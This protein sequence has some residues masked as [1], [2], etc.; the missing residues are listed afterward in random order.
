MS[1]T[2]ILTA[3][4]DRTAS[5][6]MQVICRRAREQAHYHAIL[7]PGRA[8]MTNL[9]L[10]E[11]V[12]QTGN[13]LRALG[14][15]RHEVVALCLPSGP[16][17]T[18]AFMG[19][20]S[21]AVCAPLSPASTES[22]LKYYLAGLKAK[23][24]IVPSGPSPAREVAQRLGIRIVLQVVPDLAGPA[25]RFTFDGDWPGACSHSDDSKPDDIALMLYT[26][27][28]TARAKLV[29]L[30]HRNLMASARN[31]AAPLGL[32]EQDRCLNV[33]PLFHSHGL[34]GA[35]WAAI[36]S[37]GSL[38][39]P[40]AF[41]AVDFFD[42]LTECKP[43]WYTAVPTVHQAIL[44]RAAHLGIDTF[45]SRLRLA[46]SASASMPPSVMTAIERLLG[47]PLL[48]SYGMTE[49]GLQIACNPVPPRPRKPGSVGVP[50]GTEVAIMGEPGRMLET[51][52]IG[53]I[54]LK[55]QS[56][57]S[58]Y[59][60]NPSA[61]AE[62]FADGWLR[63]GDQ[64]RFDQDGYLFITGR[65][66]EII[67]RGGELVAP[68][69]IEEVLLTHPA[70]AEA[71]A[72]AMPDQ[73]L[74]EE[75]G[76]AVV[77]RAGHSTTE[78]DL[79]EL[80]A[81][82]LSALKVPRKILA[83]SSLPKTEV[84]KLDRLRAAL[85]LGL[86]DADLPPAQSDEFAE[87]RSDLERLLA[88]RWRRALRLDRLSVNDSF[89]AL[90]GD[91]LA[92]VTMLSD[93]ERAFDA[94]L[95]LVDVLEAP[96]IASISAQL[97]QR[98]EK[99]ARRRLFSIKP[100]GSRVPF[101][102]IGGGPLQRELAE[103]LPDQPV[104]SSLFYDY[105]NMTHQCRLEDIAAEHVHTIRAEQPGGP[106]YLGGWCKHGVVAYET[107]RQLRQQGE[108]VGLVVLFNSICNLPAQATIPGLRPAQIVEKIRFNISLLSSVGMD[109]LPGFLSE[110]FSWIRGR[111]A[112]KVIRLRNR[113]RHRM[114]RTVPPAVH[115][116]LAIE[117]GANWRYHPPPYD[118]FVL[119]M[120]SQVRP[121]RTDTDLAEGW[122]KVV[123]GRLEAHE[124]P[125]DHRS[126]F[127]EP[128]VS[129][130]A[131]LL[132]QALAAARGNGEQLPTPFHAGPDAVVTTHVDPAHLAARRRPG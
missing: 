78:S 92:L 101:F 5:S 46:R 74:G 36:A 91:S 108:Q 34:L 47:V 69:E 75:I 9:D 90:G 89:F 73:R 7:S 104:L 3:M 48:E 37:G 117:E 52:Q 127:Q 70:V 16:E 125:G 12:Q 99:G 56:V 63:T 40:P 123:T 31:V 71:I 35:T 57:F 51:G 113:I 116:F 111:L 59:A 33:M 67:N 81:A 65:L 115:E 41:S 87:P 8:T 55:G 103:L 83:L 61:T 60:D 24:I 79:R 27:G 93:F 131:P 84:G 4:D 43:T 122:D 18:V 77:F 100:E 19:M 68:R 25:G 130:V 1:A 2:A 29:P 96:T 120:R 64:G 95:N 112:R 14:I 82:E 45:P 26:S 62:A 30:S 53:E 54:V 121:G 107:A 114:G 80:V 11:Q 132:A 44:A 118:G 72:F 97:E 50:F 6:V 22:E 124:V 58:G 126:L 28:T 102:L 20:I 15:T 32:T 42:L 76:A 21:C 23:A 106:Y 109:E 119:L 49:A 38:I 105:T 39:C 98:I 88:A 10:L 85:R 17:M 94:R 129:V 66:K 86:A 128:N 110:R 13:A